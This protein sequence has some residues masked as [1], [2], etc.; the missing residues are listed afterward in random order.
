MI[1]TLKLYCLVDIEIMKTY[2]FVLVLLLSFPLFAARSLFSEIIEDQYRIEPHRFPASDEDDVNPELIYVLLR[3]GFSVHRNSQ[4]DLY[5]KKNGKK[6]LVY[7]DH[8]CVEK[9]IDLSKFISKGYQISNS[10]SKLYI[11]K[12]K[13]KALIHPSFSHICFKN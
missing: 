7:N 6:Y 5:A 13:K 8:L 9:E 12:N 11:E 3:R 10:K 1:W 4:G 2:V